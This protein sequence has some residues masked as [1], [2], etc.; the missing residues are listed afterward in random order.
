MVAAVVSAFV[1]VVLGLVW[2]G[3]RSLIYLPDRSTPPAAADVLPGGQDV[4][5]TTSDGVALGAWYLPPTGTCTAAVLVAPGN[6]GNRAGRVGLA[7]AIN[8]RGPGVL[9][10]DYRGY[11]GNEGSPS[12]R[13][14]AL[15]VRAGRDFL[16]EDA[17]V[18]PGELV[19]LGESLGT[20]VVS[21]LAAAHPPAALVLR[22]P[23]T[24]LSDMARALYGVTPGPL[25]RDR[26][27]VQEHMRSIE[28]PV[29][30]V[31]GTEDSVV[32]ADQSRDVAQA[33]RAAG[34]PVVEVEIPGAG[35]NDAVLVQGPR[36][37]AA[38][39]EVVERAGI[40]GCG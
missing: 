32:P 24:S 2:F 35:H 34:V 33:A 11:G 9:V 26:Y 30:V 3:Q 38:L 17:G 4:T 36:L 6:G 31:L 22:S 40:G 37:I 12:A 7:E 8:E 23:F 28:A 15:D 39:V 1:V 16:L 14:L 13:G 5:L 18:P 10:L 19:Y 20:G 27:P 25:L 21:E 29:A